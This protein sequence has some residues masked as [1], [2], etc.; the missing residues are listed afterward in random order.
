MESKSEISEILIQEVLGKRIPS[1]RRLSPGSIDYIVVTKVTSHD[2]ATSILVPLLYFT[3]RDNG[4]N[5]LKYISDISL[6][7]HEDTNISIKI[8]TWVNG[9][10][11]QQIPIIVYDQLVTLFPKYQS[12]SI[13]I[14][15][16]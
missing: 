15:G 2:C 14:A 5:E 9:I 6:H 13:P 3:L 8:L 12:S 11:I 10:F 1:S 7:F 4:Y 16:I